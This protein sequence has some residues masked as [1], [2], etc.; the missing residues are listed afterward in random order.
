M[1]WIGDFFEALGSKERRK[2]RRIAV[3]KLVAYYWDGGV[4]IPHIIRNISLTGVYLE[5]EQRWYPGTIVTITLQK[6]DS[7]ITD[8]LRAIA[9][10]AKVIRSDADGV[11]LR[12]VPHEAGRITFE[13]PGPGE[14]ADKSVIRG[15]FD[16]LRDKG[17]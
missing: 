1:G 4:P 11:G 13:H 2:L 14:I 12:F 7:A 17:R 9:V 3:S 5:T 10:Q 6:I 15:F 16:S 8:P